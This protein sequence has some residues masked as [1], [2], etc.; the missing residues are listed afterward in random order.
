MLPKGHDPD[1]FMRQYGLE[2]FNEIAG[3]SRSVITFIMESAEKKYGLSVEGKMRIIEELKTPLAS[4][5]DTTRQ[6]AYIKEVSEHLGVKEYNLREKV[7]EAVAAI[8]KAGISS[9]NRL[10]QQQTQTDGALKKPAGKRA[11]GTRMEKQIL[12]MMLQYPEIL[13]DIIQENVLDHF[14]TDALKS[15]GRLILSMKNEKDRDVSNLLSIVDDDEKRNI[16]ASLSIKEEMWNRKGCRKIISQFIQNSPLRYSVS[17]MEQIKAAE[18]DNNQDLL[19][20]LLKEKQSIA[21]S[22]ERRKQELTR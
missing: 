19:F 20:K 22:D 13:P 1:S 21:V 16:L 17:L 3:K 18:K 7:H 14:A 6:D 10:K 12:A 11:T 15:L 2:A 9:H 5:E 8:Q 4:I